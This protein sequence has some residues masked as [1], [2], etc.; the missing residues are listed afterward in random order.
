MHRPLAML[1][2]SAVMVVFCATAAVAASSAAPTTGN[3]AQPQESDEAAM[4]NNPLLRPS[5]LPYGLP[6]FDRIHDDDFLPA[7]D[8]GMAEQ[9]QEVRAIAG[10]SEPPTFDNTIVALERSG[11]TL[12][13]VESVFFNLTASDTNP[14]L[15]DIQKQ[16]APQLAAHAD[17]IF[18]DHALF[19]RVRTLYEQRDSRD[20]DHQSRRLLERYYTMFVRAG[21][22]LDDDAQVR[23]KA[24]NRKLSTLTTAFK[25]EV[26]EGVNDAA[27]VVD[28]VGQLAGLS[29]QR[30]ATA[31][32]AAKDRG[33][34]GKYVI[35]LVN[36]TTQPV[37]AQL[38]D[39][40]L[41]KRIFDSSISRGLSGEH[42]T[43]D[44]VVDIVRTRA[45]RAKLLGYPTH[46]AYVLADETAQ[47]PAA[48]ATMLHRLA[49]PALANAKAEAARIQA[50]INQEA[51][52]AGGEPPHLQPWDWQYYAERVR[53]AEYAYDESDVRPYFEMN[54]VLEN[55]VLY[56]AEELYG[57]SFKERHDLP[58][59][60]DGVRVFEVFDHD[61]APLG[62]FL[63]DY[64]A[65]PSKR[66]GAWM[67]SFVK[68]AHLLGTK[69]VVVNNLN[70]TKPPDGEPALLTFD[71]VTTAFHE[72][73]HALHGLFS[74]VE[75]PLLSGTSVPRDF[76]EYPSQYNEMWATNPKVLAHYAHH[77]RTGEP[78][79]E[80]LLDK[81]IRARKFNQGYRTTEYLAAAMLDQSWHELVPGDIP[82]ASHVAEFESSALTNWGVSYYEVPPRYRS[83]YFSHIFANPVGYS[84]G[85][86]AYI[87]SEV[88]ARDTEH[89]FDTHGGLRRDN[90]DHLRQTVLSKGF[91]DD[92]MKLFKD[93]KGGPP[94][95][96]PLLR[97][98]GLVEE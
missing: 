59:Y 2:S 46:A 57:L 71:E 11:R 70:I 87:W 20:L 33:L 66:G 76:V 80:D 93:F 62:L 40:S 91:T 15:D 60:H 17:A 82:E 44:L 14:T 56:A 9:K 42:A 12:D 5:P 85:Y 37:L 53:R 86:Y 48:V 67:N 13:R 95:I 88:L 38:E 90:G 52:K 27:V 74:D 19:Q 72:F 24:L 83:T 25:H 18:L 23:L 68:Q 45:E 84:A 79:P 35:A 47:T 32:K 49:P 75:F 16:I 65:R 77:Y 41:R 78:M 92:A 22:L 96:G 8:A 31:A 28:D 34:E 94:D 89:W 29:Q 73:G 1:L 36:T 55:G 26:L 4:K 58:V 51:E 64:Y 97:S 98:R 43:T 50:L 3:R 39:R 30:V 61:G 81:V 54:N 69:A 63:A 21:A 10:N 7:F 6:P